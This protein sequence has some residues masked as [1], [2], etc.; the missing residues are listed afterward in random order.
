M[1]ALRLSRLLFVLAPLALAAC[2]SQPTNINDVCAVFDQKD[3]WV[4]G[5]QRDAQKA[6][7]RHGIPVP[8][9]MATI[10]MESSFDGGARPERKKI[11]GFIPGKRA[12]SAYGYSQ[13]L[14]GTWDE[15]RS[16]TGNRGARRGNFAD[17]VDFV[18][19]YHDKSARTLG[20]PRNDAYRL[21]LAY[22]HGHGGYRS[23]AWRSNPS[24]QAYARRT[25]AMAQ[26]YAAQMRSC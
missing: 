17:A 18:G 10:R 5:W 8:V 1:F 23:G 11:L 25:E 9:L 12:S 13:A 20:I 14:D 19:W 2:S 6:S 4:G 24:M 7:R 21:Y 16:V 22:Y 3:G 15:Y 26:R